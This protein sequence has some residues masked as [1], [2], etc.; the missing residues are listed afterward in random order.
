MLCKVGCFF[1]YDFMVVCIYVDKGRSFIVKVIFE[2]FLKYDYVF[3]IGWEYICIFRKEW[4]DLRV[5]VILGFW[6][7]LSE[8]NNGR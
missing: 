4:V 6:C 2:L 1:F 8:E 5:L 7:G 3:V